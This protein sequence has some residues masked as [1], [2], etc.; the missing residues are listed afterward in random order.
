MHQP[1][2]DTRRS[3]REQVL[4]PPSPQRHLL[5]CRATSI[6]AVRCA[7]CRSV[8]HSTG[9][10][11]TRLSVLV[12]SAQMDGNRM[13]RVGRQ[14]HMG[15]TILTTHERQGQLWNSRCK[16]QHFDDTDGLQGHGEHQLL[17]FLS[18]YGISS[19]CQFK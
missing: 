4:T 18:K 14:Q 12:L 1:A 8:I 11:S 17:Q 2:V 16:C 10:A 9:F 19:I 3:E 7:G 15:D 5:P 13:H 6:V